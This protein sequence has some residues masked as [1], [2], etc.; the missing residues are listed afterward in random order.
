MTPDGLLRDGSIR[1]DPNP[2]VLD[3]RA[4]GASTIVWNSVGY[5]RAEVHVD[6]PDGPL[7]AAVEQDP[8][9]PAA[10]ERAT[11]DWVSDGTQFFLQDVSDG[12]PLTRDHTIASVTVR[13]QVI[14]TAN[15]SP[16]NGSVEGVDAEMAVK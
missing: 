1:A 11:D 4:T 8:E 16:S 13:A 6:A 7:F 9:V 14:P 10:H 2:I 15:G 5:H 3:G 12:R